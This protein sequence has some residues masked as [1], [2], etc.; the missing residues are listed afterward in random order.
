M[1]QKTKRLLSLL[2][3]VAM[4][5]CMA[6]CSG[7]SVKSKLVGTWTAADGSSSMTVTFHEDGSASDING[8]FKKWSLTEENDLI[9]TYEDS[10][11]GEGT[12]TVHIAD[13]TPDTMTWE[14]DGN[15]A[16]LKKVK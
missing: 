14:M 10:N 8:E 9:M 6:A 15:T 11:T 5:L 16:K 12:V 7:G 1:N 3:A 4:L 2:L 13:I